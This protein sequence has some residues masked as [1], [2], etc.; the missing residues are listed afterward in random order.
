M[1]GS[2][3]MFSTLFPL[4]IGSS[5]RDK[6]C[7]ESYNLDSSFWLRNPQQRTSFPPAY[8]SEGTSGICKPAHTQAGT[9][10]PACPYGCRGGLAAGRAGLATILRTL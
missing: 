8:E 7:I 3:L 5:R 6:Y 4:T 10:G 9:A 2:I 1:Q